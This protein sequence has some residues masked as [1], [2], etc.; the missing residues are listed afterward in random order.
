MR[1][2]NIGI[3]K[4]TE[5]GFKFDASSRAFSSFY[6]SMPKPLKTT[7]LIGGG[8]GGRTPSQSSAIGSTLHSHFN[9]L[10]HEPPED[11]FNGEPT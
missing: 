7:V 11:R 3:K 10:D 1:A 2:L 6:K 9:Y 4:T 8:G 5:G